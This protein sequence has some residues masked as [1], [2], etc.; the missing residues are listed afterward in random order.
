MRVRVCVCARV[1]PCACVSMCIRARVCA[2]VRVCVRMCV[3]VRAC[4]CEGIE[5][6]LSLGVL[7]SQERAS[8]PSCLSPMGALMGGFP[9]LSPFMLKIM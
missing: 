4:P 2:R 5:A 9:N 3:R 1:R 7:P 6:A 8:L